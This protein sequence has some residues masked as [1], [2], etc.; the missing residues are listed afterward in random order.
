MLESALLFPQFS[1]SPFPLT[2]SLTYIH[3]QSLVVGGAG[4][5]SADGGGDLLLICLLS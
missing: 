3:R 5:S 1:F 4:G 2:H